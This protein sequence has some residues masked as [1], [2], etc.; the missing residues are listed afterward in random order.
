MVI[1]GFA[2]VCSV[3][4]GQELNRDQG[5]QMD[6]A[7]S[8][9][10]ELDQKMPKLSAEADRLESVDDV[11]KIST[12]E[13]NSFKE[14]INQLGQSLSDGLRSVSA[15]PEEN[16]EV[17]AVRDRLR[18]HA[19]AL[20]RA[21]GVHVKA[22]AIKVVQERL[23]D[24]P[25][26][27]E[28]AAL[29]ELMSQMVASPRSFDEFPEQ[30][31]AACRELDRIEAYYESMTQKYADLVSQ[32]LP[33]VL[34]FAGQLKGMAVRLNRF[35]DAADRFAERAPDQLRR[36]LEEMHEDAKRAVVNDDPEPFMET[37]P[38]AKR[39][40]EAKIKIVTALRGSEDTPVRMLLRESERTYEQLMSLEARMAD[41]IVAENRLPA[42]LYNGEDESELVEKVRKSWLAK[43][44]GAEILEIR[45][46][47]NRWQRLIVVDWDAAG[48]SWNKQDESTLEAVVVVKSDDLHARMHGA[49]LVKD[50]LKGDVITVR[51]EKESKAQPRR[52]MKLENWP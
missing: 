26:L 40:S 52:V 46:V 44:S 50:H 48:K 4:M 21:D 11:S 18:S 49:T 43:H 32:P 14:N 42:D 33:E 9:A 20:A 34:R 19:E 17:V 5:R 39:A 29:L 10:D 41:R 22:R 6:D 7:R 38:V 47:S 13:L 24:W 27:T 51:L 28:D 15:L 30:A 35:R 8:L 45:L 31:L 36:D 2:C 12:A 25:D 37:I 23:A 1:I 16:E 3:G